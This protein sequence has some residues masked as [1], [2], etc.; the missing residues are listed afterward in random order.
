MKIN[1]EGKVALVT[2]SSRGIGK[3][4][5]QAFVDAGAS[6]M[7]TARNETLLAEVAQEMGG[8]S[9]RVQYVTMDMQDGDSIQRGVEKTVEVFGKL[10][11][12]VN[13]AGISL[14]QTPF[15]Q[16]EDAQYDELMNINMR[17]VF[18]GMK[19]QLRA[20]LKNENGGS[21]VNVSSATAAHGIPMIAPYIASKLG[22]IG[23]TRSAAAEYATQKIRINA[24]VPGI[25]KTDLFDQG[26]GSTPEILAKVLMGV[27]M[28]RVGETD[29]VWGGVLWLCSEYATYVTGIALPIDGGFVL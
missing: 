12:A 6:V 1:F 5:A 10:D 14:P 8:G 15:H 19:H 22:V 17:G 3:A 29:E 2:G 11:F 24:V 20:M 21:I 25:V 28:N 27:P 23:M 26:P 16:L 9:D 13:N 7:L 4:I 18:I